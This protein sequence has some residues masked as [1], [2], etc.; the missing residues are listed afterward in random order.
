MCYSCKRK[1]IPNKHVRHLIHEMAVSAVGKNKA[2]W[3]TGHV[4]VVC[5]FEQRKQAGEASLKQSHFMEA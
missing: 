4:C 3:R 2:R 5:I 1:L